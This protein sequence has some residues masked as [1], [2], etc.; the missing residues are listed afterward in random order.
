MNEDAEAGGVDGVVEVGVFQDNQRALA[1][2]FKDKTLAALGAFRGDNAANSAGACERDELH[3]RVVEEDFGK[4]S[5][6]AGND[7]EDAGGNTG[8][9]ENFG[10][11]EADERGFLRGLEDHGIA[12]GEREGNFFQREND[13]KVEGRDAGDDTQRP[14]NRQ[15]DHAGNVGRK[16]VAVNAARFTGDGTDQIG[17]E[18]NFEVGFA[19]GGTGFVDEQF[20]HFVGSF[21]KFIG[22]THEDGFALRRNGGGPGFFGG[23]SG[24]DGG[25]HM[26]LLRH[27]NARERFLIGGIDDVGERGRLNFYIFAA[28][29]GG[30]RHVAS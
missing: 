4:G 8:T 9:R 18:R 26:F 1:A 25:A 22:R 10:E 15:R 11:L 12:A 6:V 29:V 17:G 5:A 23:V 27:E 19:E 2:H 14:A 28:D 20:D 21:L 30:G 13:G 3:A 24:I 7:I 16:N